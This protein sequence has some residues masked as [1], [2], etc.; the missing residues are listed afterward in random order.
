MNLLVVYNQGYVLS[1]FLFVPH[2]K[3][4]LLLEPLTSLLVLL[5]SVYP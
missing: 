5:C 2:K 4:S 1:L 3:R